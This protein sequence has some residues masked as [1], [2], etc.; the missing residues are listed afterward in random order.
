MNGLKFK[1]LTFDKIVEDFKG[2][3][4]WIDGKEIAS[5]D[6][7]EVLDTLEKHPDHKSIHEY[8]IVETRPYFDIFVIELKSLQ[9]AFNEDTENYIPSATNGDYSPSNPWNAPGMSIR[10]FI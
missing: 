5:G 3:S 2:V 10:N 4:V 7:S 8:E 1:Y 9:S 6:F